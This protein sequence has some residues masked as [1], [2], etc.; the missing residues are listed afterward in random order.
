MPVRRLVDHREPLGA[1][2]PIEEALITI[3]VAPSTDL[4]LDALRNFA[5]DELVYD[6]VTPRIHL[7]GRVGLVGEALASHS[8]EHQVRGFSFV[9]E[10]RREVVQVLSDAFTFSLLR[11][12]TCWENFSS[13]AMRCWQRYRSIAEP[14]PVTRISLR[15]INRLSLPSGKI[16][17]TDWTRLHPTVPDVLGHTRGF[18]VR[19]GFAHPDDAGLQAIASFGTISPEGDET[20][21]LFDINTWFDDQRTRDLEP[22]AMLHD[23][24]EFKNDIF[25]GSLTPKALERI[26]E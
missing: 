24:R 1:K 15:Y 6:K 12:Y 16:E 14:G 3:N 22:S 7:D 26:R 23:L 9:S 21:L 20:A 13:G 4:E 8:V 19:S 2:A 5:T 25:F 11:P 17:L 10:V 18:L